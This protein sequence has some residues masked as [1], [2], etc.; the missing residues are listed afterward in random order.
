[1]STD[2]ELVAA[3]WARYDRI[4]EDPDRE[5]ALRLAAMRPLIEARA[6]VISP[7]AFAGLLRSA[8]DDLFGDG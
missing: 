8:F 3:F 7:E 6:R 5:R 2:D 4:G 1:M